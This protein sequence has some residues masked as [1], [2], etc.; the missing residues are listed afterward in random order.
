VILGKVWVDHYGDIKLRQ[1][2]ENG[3]VADIKFKECGYFSKH[4]R[5]IVGSIKNGEDEEIFKI[6]GK[7]NDKIYGTKLSDYNSDETEDIFELDK[8][9]MLWECE[10][11]YVKEKPYKKYKFTTAT[12]KSIEIV[13]ELIGIIAPSDSRYRPDRIALEKGDTKTATAE[14]NKLEE[15]QRAK[16]KYRDHHGIE[17]SPRYFEIKEINGLEYWS[18]NYKYD[19][20][21]E[22][23]LALIN[24]DTEREIIFVVDPLDIENDEP[25]KNG[26]IKNSKGKKKES[27]DDSNEKKDSD[28]SDDKKK[29]SDESVPDYSENY[30][31][32]KTHSDDSLDNHKESDI[33]KVSKKIKSSRSKRKDSEDVRINKSENKPKD[34]NSDNNEKRIK[35]SRSKRKDTEEVKVS[36]IKSSRGKRKDT[37]DE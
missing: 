32:K 13:P 21:R 30:E 18:Y 31:V 26:E 16:R 11:D 35:S 12:M 9:K 19:E 27:S 34:D 3:I 37:E 17:Y 4:Y 22:E 24:N 23:R 5:E 25:H 14:K 2:I 7:W 28:N 33:T 8:P 6:H 15:E 20:E 36:K 10:M 29:D 1:T